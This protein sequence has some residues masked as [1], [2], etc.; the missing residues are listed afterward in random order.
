MAATSIFFIVDHRLEGT[1]CSSPPAA[2]A[3][4]SGAARDLPGEAPAILAP[5]T[6]AFRSASATIAFQ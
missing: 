3:S 5:T 6:C 4:V 2:S 1:L